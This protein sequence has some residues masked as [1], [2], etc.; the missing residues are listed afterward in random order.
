MY[1]NQQ[2]IWIRHI[3]HHQYGNKCKKHPWWHEQVWHQY[4]QSHFI[5]KCIQA[6]SVVKKSWWARESK[7]VGENHLAA[8]SPPSQATSVSHILT[9]VL[10]MLLSLTRRSINP[11]PWDNALL[12]ANGQGGPRAEPHYLRASR[13]N[14]LNLFLNF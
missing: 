4:R 1:I 14:L 3:W 13:W 7:R 8:L 11:R 10:T 9:S 12:S 5:C 2:L 6:K